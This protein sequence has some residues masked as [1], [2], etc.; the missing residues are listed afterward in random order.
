VDEIELPANGEAVHQ[1]NEA[2]DKENLTSDGSLDPT[3]L[4]G[5]NSGQS[6]EATYGSSDAHHNSQ[7]RLSSLDS[8]DK[9]GEIGQPDR[10]S[11][12][13][14]FRSGP[15]RTASMSNHNPSAQI[16]I[17]ILQSQA[18][19]NGDLNATNTNIQN[20]SSSQAAWDSDGLFP[21]D[22][23]GMPGDG[24][25]SRGANLYTP[26]QSEE[27]DLFALMSSA[28]P[29]MDMSFLNNQLQYENSVLHPGWDSLGR[30]PLEMSHL[31]DGGPTSRSETGH[32]P[33][34]EVPRYVIFP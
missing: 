5:V 21:G 1:F 24:H 4:N 3:L 25:M 7:Q 22:V 12:A 14:G 18:S 26:Q 19:N 16:S 31:R 30:L 32:T 17:Q 33:D 2:L 27:I 9:L 28:T 6:P 13:Q 11:P 23:Y 29:Q 15:G 10:Q 20:G 34:S 8:A